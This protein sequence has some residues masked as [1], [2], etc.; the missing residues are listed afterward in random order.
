MNLLKSLTSPT[1]S[2]HLERHDLLVEESRL[3]RAIS[4]FKH[5]H[6]MIE[7]VPEAAKR[8]Q[9]VLREITK[10]EIQ[11][12]CIRNLTRECRMRIGADQKLS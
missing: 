6:R 3:E 5:H 1:S 12:N 7:Y 2:G 8:A 11:L 9:Y 10:L 4:N